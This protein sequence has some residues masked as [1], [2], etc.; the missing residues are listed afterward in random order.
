[1]RLMILKN[2]ISNLI[3]I[4]SEGIFLLHIKQITEK[5]VQK[6]DKFMFH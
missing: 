6:S 4:L 1:M 3:L 5:T 2:Y